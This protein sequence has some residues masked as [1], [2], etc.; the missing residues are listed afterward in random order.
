MGFQCRHK[1]FRNEEILL[2]AAI[3]PPFAHQALHLQAGAYAPTHQVLV[4][5]RTS[6]SDLSPLL[7]FC[8]LLF[9]RGSM[10]IHRDAGSCDLRAMTWSA[11]PRLRARRREVPGVRHPRPR[12]VAPAEFMA[13][14]GHGGEIGQDPEKA[15]KRKLRIALCCSGERKLRAP[16]RGRD[17]SW[18]PTVTG[19]SQ[20]PCPRPKP[21]CGMRG[22]EAISGTMRMGRAAQS[23]DAYC[24]QSRR[25]GGGHETRPAI[26]ARSGG[27]GFFR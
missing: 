2:H 7:V 1:I 23:W 22:N 6:S 17:R 21:S 14:H 9:C 26:R 18:C 3:C 4:T 20:T 19:R 8:G 25:M 12:Y 13:R 11:A 16:A 5:I 15:R 10:R 24:A 27:C